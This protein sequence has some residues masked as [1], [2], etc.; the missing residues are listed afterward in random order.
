MRLRHTLLYFTSI[1]LLSTSILQA[2]E[3]VNEIEEV[4][5]LQ[6]KEATTDTI[7][8]VNN[9]QYYG[10][11]IGVDL[12]KP[13]RSLIDDDYSGFEVV[14]DFRIKKKYYL[15]AA[16]GS[17]TR[18]SDR[19]NIENITEGS[20]IKA[21][22]IYN[23][24][25]NW[26]GMNNLLYAGVSAGFSTFN[27]E[28]ESFIISTDNSVF[29]DDIIGDPREFND[30]TATWLEV[31]VGLEAE[32]LKNVYLGINLQLKRSITATE[33]DGFTNLF[34]PGFGKVT[35]DSN[36]GVGF[37]YTISYLIPFFKK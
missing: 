11:R 16:I 34:I 26:F 18:T 36:S 3:E 14:G 5:D 25:N 12:S 9:S 7:S 29:P 10:L 28:L 24:Y 8:K 30:L 31:R 32:V 13:L 33:P 15:T 6:E 27:Q 20:Y 1:L 21:G 23:A 19:P 37:G 17:E 35:E 2:Q 4:K 22:F